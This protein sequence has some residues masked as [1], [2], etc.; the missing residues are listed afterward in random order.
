MEKDRTSR[1]FG[2]TVGFSPQGVC[3][4]ETAAGVCGVVVVTNVIVF[5]VAFGVM[6]VGKLNAVNK[7]KLFKSDMLVVCRSQTPRMADGPYVL[8]IGL[9]TPLS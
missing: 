4:V 2:C 7:C 6:I 5:P 8:E 1:D 9:L 3:S